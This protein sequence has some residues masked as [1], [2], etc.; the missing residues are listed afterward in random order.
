M[1]LYSRNLHVNRQSMAWLTF[2]EEN[3][4]I[5]LKLQAVEKTAITFSNL[6]TQF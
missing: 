2:H 6:P 3:P 5:G 1:I 4:E